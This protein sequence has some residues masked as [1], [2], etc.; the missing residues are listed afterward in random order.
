MWNG[1]AVGGGGSLP[2]GTNGQTLYSSSGRW[3]ATSN[4][5]NDGTSVGIGTATPANTLDI[6][7]SGGIH[8]TS[9]IPS[10]TGMALYNNSGTL[11]WNGSA[12]G[13]G[14]S[15]PPGTN[16]QTLYSSSGI[17][18]A[19]SNLFNDGTS[20]GIGTAT[21]A[22]TLDIGNS[23][24]IHITSG[25]PSSTG[26][27]LYNNSGTLMWNGSAVGGGGSLP[28]G[29][30]GQTLYSSSGI[31][32]ATSNLFNDGTSV[33]IGTA[34]PANT[35]DIGNSGG[36]HITSG[37]PSSTGMALYNNSGTLMWNG[38]A[39][40]GGGSLPPGTNGQTLYSS[41]GIWTATSNL[42]N[43]GTSVGIG[44]ATPANTLD[45][46]N[47][48]G[49]HITSGIPSSTGMALYNNSGTLMWNGSAVGGGGS[50]P[51][52][53]NGQTLY[54]SSGIWTATSNLFNDGTSVGIGTATPANTLD[55]G[56]SGGIHHF[57]NP[58]FH[59][60]GSL[61]QFRHAYV[62]RLGGRRRRFPSSGN[63][64]SDTLQ[65]F[66]NM[67]RNLKSF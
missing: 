18:T 2:P 43:D 67:D 64:W 21:P 10:S 11:M 40:G 53:T 45:I 5:F 8:I 6:G 16:G 23:G 14:G 48:G 65:F 50:L 57:R 38:S 63:E 29:T 39:V 49:I 30:N 47:S 35:L 46:G 28:P 12:V 4:L 61:Q 19:T 13:G 58:V 60:H 20:V 51:P 54:S 32:T 9:G 56:N 15:L 27:A 3:T 24:G 26:M 31:W 44:T 37:I 42:F 22:N 59:R 62:E 33:G 36:I 1:S 25:I 55:I 17:W 52:G 34:T 7:N 41:S 66:R